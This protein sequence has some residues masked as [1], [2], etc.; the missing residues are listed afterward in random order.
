MA[1]LSSVRLLV[2]VV[3]V[4]LF[5]FSLPIHADDDPLKAALASAHDLLIKAHDEIDVTQRTSDLKEAKA[6]IHHS[7]VGGL[8][9]H[10]QKA[11]DLINAAIVELKQGDPKDLVNRYIEDANR[12]IGY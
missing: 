11:V 2:V 6:D 7:G 12:E 3:A 5:S 10:R 9:P 8:G 1:H 4:S